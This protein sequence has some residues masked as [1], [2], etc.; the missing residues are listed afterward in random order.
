MQPSFSAP[1]MQICQSSR[2]A[3][4]KRLFFANAHICKGIKKFLWCVKNRDLEDH[5]HKR[6]SLDPI[7]WFSRVIERLKKIFLSEGNKKDYMCVKKA[8]SIR[9]NPPDPQTHAFASIFKE[10]NV[11]VCQTRAKEADIFLKKG[12]QATCV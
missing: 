5:C 8:I 3:E 2:S 6:S 11:F 7:C 12:L 4:T 10:V 9:K 1:F